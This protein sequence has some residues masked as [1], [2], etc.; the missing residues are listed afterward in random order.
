MQTIACP[1]CGLGISGTPKGKIRKHNRS[2]MKFDTCPASGLTADEYNALHTPT[3]PLPLPTH[4][5]YLPPY[6]GTPIYRYP[7]M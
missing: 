5:P 6:T 3:Y 4:Y 1:E 2:G 7:L